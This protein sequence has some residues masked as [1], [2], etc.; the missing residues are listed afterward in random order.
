MIGKFKPLFN[1]LFLN[2]IAMNLII[3]WLFINFKLINGK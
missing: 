3:G 1:V 2:W